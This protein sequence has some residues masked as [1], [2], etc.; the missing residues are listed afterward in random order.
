MGTPFY[1]HL[2]INH[3]F[4]YWHSNFRGSTPFSDT[5][6]WNQSPY[7]CGQHCCWCCGLRGGIAQHVDPTMVWRSGSHY[8]SLTSKNVVPK[9]PKIALFIVHHHFIS[10]FLSKSATPVNNTV[11]V[12]AK[13]TFIPQHTCYDDTIQALTHPEHLFYHLFLQVS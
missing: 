10:F 3:P 1:L 4:P 6:M 13:W 5:S 9:K 7:F 8:R 11:A 2:L 12:A